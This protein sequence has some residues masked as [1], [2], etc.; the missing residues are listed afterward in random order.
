M[1]KTYVLLGILLIAASMFLIYFINR[2]SVKSR[3]VA[4]LSQVIEKSEVDVSKPL[5][6]AQPLKVTSPSARVD[7][8]D[9][10]RRAIDAFLS[11]DAVKSRFD[12]GLL[13][14]INNAHR[15][16][17]HEHKKNPEEWRAK[18]KKID[19]TWTSESMHAKYRQILER[20]LSLEQLTHLNAIYPEVESFRTLKT[21]I[22]ETPE[23]LAYIRNFNPNDL[24]PE[25]L[26]ALNETVRNDYASLDDGALDIPDKSR[27]SKKRRI[28][29]KEVAAVNK[30]LENKSVE[31]IRELNAALADPVLLKEQVEWNRLIAQS[32]DEIEE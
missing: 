22:E 7:E 28:R 29:A 5:Q 9:T 23:Y 12:Y 24:A 16:I 18:S 4:T 32:L 26:D 6:V 30:I 8:K 17:E 21:N 1:K 2:K 27:D 20:E 3:E 19:A 10:K 11:R 15:N 31:E 13:V 14:I 25:R